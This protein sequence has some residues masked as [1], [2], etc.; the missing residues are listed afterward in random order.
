MVKLIA[1][2]ANVID[3]MI[4]SSRPKKRICEPA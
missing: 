3:I 2:T 4:H 1:T